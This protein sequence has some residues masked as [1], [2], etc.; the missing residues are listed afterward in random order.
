GNNSA[1]ADTTVTNQADVGV[2][3][4]DSPDPV[5]PGTSLTYTVT[6]TNSGPT[7]AQNVT[8]TDA[9]PANTTFVSAMQTSG[10]S[11]SLISPPAGGGGIVTGTAAALAASASA[12][13]Q[14]VVHV[15]PATPGGTIISNTATASMSSTV[16][17]D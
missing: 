4:T 12:I 16:V 8:F 15:N 6:I 9:V 5:V 17:V 2:T 7:T 3:K 1:T 10:P 11:F 14:I 13:F